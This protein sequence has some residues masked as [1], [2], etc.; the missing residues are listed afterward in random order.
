MRQ[1]LFIGESKPSVF[2]ERLKRMNKMLQ[3]FPRANVFDDDNVFIEEE[4]LIT[5]VHH[6][7]HGIMQLQIQRAGR[8]INEFKMLEDLKVFF[9]QQ[10]DCDMLEKRIL[11]NDNKNK[12]NKKQKK[13]KKRKK[14]E[15]DD[16]D[17]AEKGDQKPAAKP[18]CKHCGKIGHSDDNCWSLDKNAKKRP[19]NYRTANAIR[20]KPKVAA[21]AS[22]TNTAALFTEEQV[23]VMMKRVMASM[24][25]KYGHK[26][27]PKRQVRVEEENALA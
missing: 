17:E 21:A 20:K 11:S 6:A 10:H 25:D 3:Y 7:S 14:N 1:N 26:K 19:A 15:D 13:T 2:I 16:A 8:T 27:K 5:I 12:N 4:Q 9:T 23:S 22:S 24:K 18:K